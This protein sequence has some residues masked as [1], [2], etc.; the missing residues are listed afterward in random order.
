M[1]LALCWLPGDASK[2]VSHTLFKSSPQSKEGYRASASTEV[3]TKASVKLEDRAMAALER[4]AGA[5]L[6]ELQDAASI[7][8]L[9]Q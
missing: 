7:L 8:V 6:S 3:L 4:E 2:S 5:S 1:L 9:L